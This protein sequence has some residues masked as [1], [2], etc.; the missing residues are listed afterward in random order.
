MKGLLVAA[1]PL[2]LVAARA[3]APDA[4]PA[5]F[6]HD[7]LPL[8]QR[9][10]CSSAYCHGSATGRG[11]FKLSLFGSDP[12][13]DYEA[14]TQELDGR[15]ID[16]AE[17]ERSLLLQKPA[18]RVPH[19]GGRRLPAG[20]EEYRVLREWIVRGTPW[21]GGPARSLAGLDLAL[22][23]GALRAR[24]RFDDGSTRDVTGLATFTSSD[25]EVATVSTDGTV[26]LRDAGEAW[27]LARYGNQNARLAVRR[28]FATVPVETSDHPL[29]R[30]WLARLAELGLAPAP[31][32]GAEI[33]RRRLY[34]DLAGRP[35]APHEQDQCDVAARV[36]ALLER[37]EFAETFGAHLARWLGAE[38]ARGLAD[39]VARGDSLPEIARLVLERELGTRRGDPRDRAEH[40]GRAFLGIRIGCAR[41]HDHPLD[42]GRRGEHLAFAA[43][44]AD[45]RPAP[46]G[47]TTDG[48]LFDPDTGEEVAP[49]L[50]PLDG[51]RA[52]TDLVAFVLDE[53]HGLLAQNLANRVFAALVGRG[54]VEG[55]DDHRLSN[56]PVHEALLAALVAEWRRTGG[57]LRALVRTIA[58]SRLYAASSEA[59]A[60]DPATEQARVRWFARREARPL[61]DAVLARSF[62]FVLGVRRP[63]MG[64]VAPLARQL[65]VQNGPLLHEALA[66]GTL[67]DSVL[68][69]G[70]RDRRLDG[71][72]ALVLARAPRAEER[73]KFQPLLEG[74]DPRTALRD[75]AFALLAG[76]EFSSNR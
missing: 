60:G 72:Y 12:R 9:A 46:G 20:G 15:R 53:G 24:A 13:A 69:L 30:V 36:D 32:A 63:A 59:A 70:P 5:D 68:D 55:Q 14:I 76:R 43:C 37:R 49:A 11:G 38:Q 58:T 61:D 28:P 21:H 16:R 29:D 56:P 33:L 66:E 40:V 74:D 2:A 48:K 65:A 39:A 4:A 41:C 50:L 1:A 23:G 19:G 18:L 35:P 31:P 67:V 51:A 26:E 10:G 52:G 62:A 22:E 42:R 8:L 73:A 71:L 75:L 6:T 17:P 64:A 44:F 27:L 45:P 34:L 54:L 7:V 25:P 47:G 57:D 3:L